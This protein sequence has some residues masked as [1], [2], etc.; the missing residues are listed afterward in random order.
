MRVFGCASYPTLRDYAHN[1]FDPRAFQCVFL[2]YNAKYK[3]YRC[4]LPSTGRVYISRHVLFDEHVFPFSSIY[5]HLHT[6]KG[7]PLLS[8]WQQNFVKPAVFSQATSSD[9]VIQL[10]SM[11]SSTQADSQISIASSPLIKYVSLDS[12]HD[13][14][15][16]ATTPVEV[17]SVTAEINTECTT[18]LCPDPIGNSALSPASSTETSPL[19]SPAHVNTTHQ[20]V[21]RFKAGII[22]P[23][24]RYVLLTQKVSYPE[25]KTV[26]TALKDPGWT[27]A[28]NEEMDNCSKTNTW[29]LVPYRSDM[30][31]LGNKWM[32]RTKLNDDGSLDKLRVRI[33]AKGFNQEE[34]IDYLET[35]SHVVRSANC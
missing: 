9:P 3:G 4:L 2:G 13:Y 17:P 35:Y 8:A 23:N 22:K 6:D 25:P 33:M 34:D 28:M 14:N 5:Q 27:D 26:T 32:F 24:P 30:H 29:S 20:M 15:S 1:K 10:V 16:E 12:P 31:V 19:S 18:G 11:S 7:T 21:T